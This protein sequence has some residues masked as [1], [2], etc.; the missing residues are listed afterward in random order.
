MYCLMG[1]LFISLGGGGRGVGGGGGEGVGFEEVR[2][3]E[4][5][6]GS[7]GWM[8]EEREQISRG[9]GGKE[10]ESRSGRRGFLPT[11]KKQG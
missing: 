5:V 11:W 6:R 7:S 9:K 2:E 10:R 8:G 3:V 4:V 1:G